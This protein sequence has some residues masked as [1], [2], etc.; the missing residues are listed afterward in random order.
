MT[1]HLG[2]ATLVFLLLLAP[3][4]GRAQAGWIF[5]PGR[6]SH[7]PNTGE[8]VVQYE[9]PK[10]AYV[11]QDPTY[12]E[13][14]YRQKRSG[15]Q[16]GGSYDYRHVVQT[17][18][19]GEYI[20]PYGEWLYPYRE[21]AT[22]YGPWGNPQGPWTLPF[23]SW[24]NPYGAWNKFGYPYMPGGDPMPPYG[25]SWGPGAGPP[26]AAVPYA[27]NGTSAGGPRGS[28]YRPPAGPPAAAPDP[29]VP[30]VLPPGPHSF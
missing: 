20:R 28:A 5:G 23:D 24:V 8:R 21:G 3:A 25:G 6:Y 19:E 27:P 13:S 30:P 1:R 4:D 14:G 9:Q 2:T 10:P 7:A 18:G 26:I 17:W 12:M 15:L 29:F 22:P 16:V 11:P